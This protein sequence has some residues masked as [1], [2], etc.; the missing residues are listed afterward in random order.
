MKAQHSN[1]MGQE[2]SI[3]PLYI[4]LQVAGETTRMTA[5]QVESW[6]DC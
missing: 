6:D 1:V 5:D 3:M 2:E 4:L